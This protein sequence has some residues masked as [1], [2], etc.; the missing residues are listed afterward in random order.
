MTTLSPRTHNRSLFWPVILISVGVIWLLGNAGILR[1]ANLEM[2]FRLWPLILIAIGLD[3]LLGRGNPGLRTLI[4]IGAVVLV[5]VLMLVGPSL[6]WVQNI[7]VKKAN[8]EEPRGD[9]QSALVD[10]QMGVAQANVRALQDSNQLITADLNYI[11]E[12]DFTVSGTT[13]KTV[14]LTQKNQSISFGFT[15]FFGFGSAEDELRW[16]V[17]LSP[18]V[19]MNLTVSTGVGESNLDLSGLKLRGLDVNAGVGKV[20]LSLPSMDESYAVS[21]DSGTGEAD[22]RIEEGA[23]ITFTISGGVGDISIDVPDDAAVRLDGKT[24]VGSINVPG[25]YERMDSASDNPSVGED[26]IWQSPNYDSATR[27]IVIEFNG[28]VGSLKIR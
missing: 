22:I 15:N 9:A 13:D 4:A 14:A 20:T 17:A 23:A 6:G 24:G 7:E 11:G 1:A 16:D 19:P 10:L 28:G 27:K 8:F 12:V 21:L 25:S 26:G 18:D 2:L 5:I 3:I